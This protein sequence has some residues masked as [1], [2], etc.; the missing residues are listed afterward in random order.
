MKCADGTLYT[1]STNDLIKRLKDHNES[2][3]GAKYTYTRRPVVLCYFEELNSLS[4][5]LR[6]E[7]LIKSWRKKKKLELIRK[8]SPSSF[9]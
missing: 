7:I 5:A 9:N 2:K 1:G 8:G 6:R 4:E 3:V